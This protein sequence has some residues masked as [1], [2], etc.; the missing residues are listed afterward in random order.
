M[1]NKNNETP[2]CIAARYGSIECLKLLLDGSRSEYRE[3]SNKDGYDAVY[4]ADKFGHLE[5]V[6]VLKNEYMKFAI[7]IEMVTENSTGSEEIEFLPIMK[8]GSVLPAETSK[9]FYV[10]ENQKMA[11]FRIY[12]GNIK[13]KL[14]IGNIGYVLKNSSKFSL[15][16]DIQCDGKLKVTLG[17]DGFP[18]TVKEFDRKHHNCSDNEMNKL[19]ESSQE[20]Q[21][22][23]KLQTVARAEQKKLVEKLNDIEKKYFNMLSVE[24]PSNKEKLSKIDDIDL[25]ITECR[26]W[27]EQVDKI[28]PVPSPEVFQQKLDETIQRI[29]NV[30]SESSMKPMVSSVLDESYLQPLSQHLT[31]VLQGI[32]NQQLELWTELKREYLNIESSIIQ[33]LQ[34]GSHK[35]KLPNFRLATLNGIAGHFENKLSVNQAHSF[36]EK[37][38]HLMGDEVPRNSKWIPNGFNV[39]MPSAITLEDDQNSVSEGCEHDKVDVLPPSITSIFVSKDNIARFNTLV[40][41]TYSVNDENI[42]QII[43]IVNKEE[44]LPPKLTQEVV[45]KG[46][47]Q[48]VLFRIFE[49]YHENAEDNLYLG[50]MG[51]ILKKH[52]IEAPVIA[53]EFD[54]HDDDKLVMSVRQCDEASHP[55]QKVFER[56][57][58]KCSDEEIEEM[59]EIRKSNDKLYKLQRSARVEQR[60]LIQ[61]LN[62]L[63]KKY[64]N[65]SDMTS[66]DKEAV[67]TIDEIDL[68][69]AET[70]KW[71][72]LV[73]T[74]NPIPSSEDFQ[75]KF[76]E[77][78][79]RINILMMERL[80]IES[81]EE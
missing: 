70:R 28:S 62:E 72:E 48:M 75:Q 73:Q 2:L 40:E 65:H 23:Y 71:N 81:F 38:R 3:M 79:E 68:I 10:K 41:M 43:P 14:Y 33:C 30:A 22:L 13:D 44:I 42:V 60:K 50:N 8:E 18:P 11:F 47:P 25:I 16:L 66:L 9:E 21:K 64:Y 46:D 69:I 67:S 19:I 52:S 6:K 32:S 49:G 1:S 7:G 55:K 80:T 35:L 37:L 77:T 39:P 76:K 58:Y 78:V 26:E 27:N 57:Y 34:M 29:K 61:K 12:E 20:T 53:L 31:I 56:N 54:F 4:L 5:C 15:T 74:M 45:I 36:L 17:Q 63:E 24:C 59:I 51:Y